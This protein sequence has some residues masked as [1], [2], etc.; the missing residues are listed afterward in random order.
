PRNRLYVSGSGFT[1]QEAALRFRKRLYASGSGS[2]SQEAAL[3]LRKRL[4]AP[5]HEFRRPEAAREGRKSPD[6]AMGSSR[7]AFRLAERART[8]PAGVVPAGRRFSGQSTS[9]PIS[10][11]GVVDEE[12]LLLAMF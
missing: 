6:P 4:H 10:V 5:G 12:L 8:L 9:K 11:T 3:R 2:T 1:C 7:S